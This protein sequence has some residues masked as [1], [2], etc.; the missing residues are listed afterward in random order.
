L[1]C[2]KIPQAALDVSNESQPLEE[3]LCSP[4]SVSICKNSKLCLFVWVGTA[5]ELKKAKGATRVR[6]GSNDGPIATLLPWG[7]RNGALQVCSFFV[8]RRHKREGRIDR[9]T[10]TEGRRRQ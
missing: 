4:H 9:A 8:G 2:T 7:M 3:I 1:R 10:G 6:F 5:L